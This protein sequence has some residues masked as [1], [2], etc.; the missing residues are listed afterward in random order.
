MPLAIKFGRRPVY[1]F[2]NLLMGIACI[3]QGL[4]CTSTYTAFFV[5]RA[6]LGIVE[7]PI[8]SI[9]PTTITDMFFL[10]D[11]GEKVSA[12]GLSVLGGNEL[13]PLFSAL[14]VQYL[15]NAW[16]F[17]IV[18]MFIFLNVAT[19]FFTMPETKY[20]GN[21][22]ENI[23]NADE[24]DEIAEKSFAQTVEDTAKSDSASVEAAP[25][26]V[27]KHSYLSELRFWGKSDPDVNLR[28]V[29]LR[30]FVLV[31]YPTVIWA[32][33]VY[34][35]SLGWNVIMGATVAQLFAPP[36]YNFNS[37]AQ[38][39]VFL[40]PFVGSII[41]SWLCGSVSDSI[42][43]YFT[44]KN[45]G[46]R[47]P[48][49]RLPTLAIGTFL[50]LFGTLMTGLTYHYQTHWAGPVVGFGVLTAGAQMGVSLSMTYALDC[51]KELSVELMVAVASI[52]S[53]IAW[54]WTWIINDWIAADGM[55]MVF[56]IIAGINVVVHLS[57]ILL[58]L[59]GK[60]IR[61]WIHERDM[62]GRCGLH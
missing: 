51:H 57:T 8:E 4:A 45:G 23:W 36:P 16:A 18:A 15:G 21:R 1:L 25:V 39:L 54:I 41:G 6:F 58:F 37:Q 31:T 44:L 43:N 55:L 24:V 13:G 33:F 52:K 34:G 47:E 30:P 2:S 50:T 53:S 3:W 48:E 19:M 42:A 40:S 61:V 32:C 46:I 28:K 7:A 35:M 60:S 11:R 56:M 29:F 12:Y 26:E 10:H 22:P 17:Y 9:V 59:K 38:G 20:R 49:M 14:I 62:L 27:P 5:G